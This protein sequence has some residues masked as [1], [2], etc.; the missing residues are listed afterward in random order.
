MDIIVDPTHEL[1]SQSAARII[2]DAI[3]AKPNL[4]LLIATGNTPIECYRQLSAIVTSEHIDTSR[5]V[6]VQL[7][8]YVS[9]ENNSNAPSLFDWM[10]R[11]LLQP[12]VI[13][14]GNVVRFEMGQSM[15][16]ATVDVY[17][18]K[19]GSIGGIDLAILGLGPNGHLGFN[20]PPSAPDAPTRLVDL[21]P[22]SL[23][24]NQPYW[25]DSQIVPSQAFTAGMTT[26]L[27]ARKILLLVSGAHKNTVLRH[28]ITGPVSDL[29]P[30][31]QLQSVSGNVTILADN[32][33]WGDIERR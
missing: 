30:A 25:D 6:A 11:E 32:A 17:D 13:D 12:L 19:V 18:T 4:S 29:L 21:T 15:P 20:E 14:S 31:S 8:E 22:E 33:A 23:I 2:A 28:A 16:R 24:S 3:R 5:L 27:G 9:P 10:Q 26:I 1:M 7:D